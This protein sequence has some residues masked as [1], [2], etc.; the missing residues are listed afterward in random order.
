[1]IKNDKRN[2]FK[3]PDFILQISTVLPPRAID[4]RIFSTTMIS[5]SPSSPGVR[6][7]ADLLKL[8]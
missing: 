5:F 6:Q 4:S 2:E 3:I 1:M 7:N 8:S